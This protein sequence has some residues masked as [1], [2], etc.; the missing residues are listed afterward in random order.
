VGCKQSQICPLLDFS[1]V[2]GQE[3][4]ST[5]KKTAQGAVLTFR[6]AF[7]PWILVLAPFKAGL[8]SGHMARSLTLSSWLIFSIDNILLAA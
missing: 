1:L 4:I 3:E 2:L 8:L 5:N 6:F 7:A